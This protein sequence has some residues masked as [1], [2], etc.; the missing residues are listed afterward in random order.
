MLG[1]FSEASTCA[2]RWNRASRSGSART[3]GQ[4][5]QR[6]IAIELRVMRAPDLA[7]AAF[8]EQARHLIGT[9]TGAGADGHSA[10]F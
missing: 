9:D 6:D 4:D 3:I 5:L 10:R 7:H 2:S 1:W 8:A